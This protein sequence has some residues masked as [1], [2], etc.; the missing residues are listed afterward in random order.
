MPHP[1]SSRKLADSGSIV[2][3]CCRRKNPPKQSWSDNLHVQKQL[4]PSSLSASKHQSNHQPPIN[5]F[6]PSPSPGGGGENNNVT[7][8]QTTI[9]VG[10]LLVF[11]LLGL[12]YFVKKNRKLVTNGSA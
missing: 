10:Y 3:T 1:K 11:L 5:I 6:A 12:F 2:V 8:V 4:P 9:G 7:V